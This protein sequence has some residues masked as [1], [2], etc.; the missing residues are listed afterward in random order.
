MCL[1]VLGVGLERILYQA[2]A[3]VSAK[4]SLD[5]NPLLTPLGTEF[6]DKT[7]EN[8]REQVGHHTNFHCHKSS[9]G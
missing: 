8:S 1:C 3:W 2:L 6:N 7:A 5:L 9:A 4:L